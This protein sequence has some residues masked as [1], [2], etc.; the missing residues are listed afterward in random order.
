MSGR[1][2]SNSP[3]ARF[4]GEDAARG[5]PFALLGVSPGELSDAQILEARDRRMR[6]IDAHPLAE[7]PEADEVRLSLYAAA[8]QLLNPVIRGQ[9]AQSWGGAKKAQTDRASEPKRP[10]VHPGSPEQLLEHDA[11]LAL[12]MFGG[13]NPRSLRR[14]VSIAHARG[15]GS[16]EVARTLRRLGRQ[17]RPRAVRPVPSRPTRPS[18]QP[19]PAAAPA[20][21]SLL[22]P[23]PDQ[24]DPAQQLLKMAFI[25]GGVAIVTLVVLFGGVYALLA[26][27]NARAKQAE[28]QAAIDDAVS[29][30]DSSPGA[31]RPRQSRPAPNTRVLPSPAALGDP[32]L[33]V[34][35]IDAARRGLE[36][37]PYESTRRFTDAVA[38]LASSWAGFSPTELDRANQSVERFVETVVQPDV[39]RL[40]IDA[41]GAGAVDLD[42]RGAPL[43]ASRVWSIVWSGGMLAQIQNAHVLSATQRS[44]IT[45]LRRRIDPADVGARGF[46]IGA[47]AGAH[48]VAERMAAS[49]GARAAWRRWVEVVDALARERELL[50]T[51]MLTDAVDQLLDSDAAHAERAPVIRDLAL[52]MSWRRQGGARR[53]LV[54]L[55][56]RS[57]VDQPALSALMDTLVSESAAIGLDATM[58][59]SPNATARERQVLADRLA[60]VWELGQDGRRDEFTRELI[61]IF[62]E[63]QRERA[64]G[65]DPI[66]R[67]GSVVRLAYANASAALARAE[68]FEEAGR[69][70]DAAASFRPARPTGTGDDPFGAHDDGQLTLAIHAAGDSADQKL[71]AI[72]RLGQ[73]MASNLG[74][75]DAETLLELSIRGGPRSVRERATLVVQ[76]YAASPAMVNALLERA[77]D[78]PATQQMRDLVEIVTARPVPRDDDSGAWRLDARRALLETLIEA[79]AS[80]GRG[81]IVAS[82][83]DEFGVAY[84]MAMG[85][86]ISDDGS[87]APMSPA[88]AARALGASLRREIERSGGA[89][90]SALR[91][92]LIEQ[93]RLERNAHARTSLQAFLVEQRSICESLGVLV[94]LDQRGVSGEVARILESLEQELQSADHVLD[95]I[96][97]TEA[98]I[99]RLWLLREG[100]TP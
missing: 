30:A 84:T 42:D 16:A 21:V 54:L 55:L 44:Q 73:R 97:A 10:P 72:D 7:T 37:T 40:T 19:K 86:S 18:T 25:V 51:D 80:G 28:T 95:Q 14:I 27:D 22:D 100:V 56:Q 3:T 6:L 67:L 75:S 52:A 32:S 91:P 66:V 74:P 69:A 33:I 77:D 90:A 87:W 59:L 43:D 35:E 85:D 94:A 96:G 41:I 60:Q 15:L 53:W 2:G 12:A 92:G 93:R 88:D 57:D 68:R 29:L 71:E 45:R 8:A 20:P 65:G 23:T 81:A 1:P 61:A 11:I 47:V 31:Q 26:S 4:L 36:F 34:H 9:L 83:E 17:R 48:A 70:L 63:A 76:R 58:T 24:I 39:M 13:W 82:C 64:S 78:L 38:L 89:R 79:I 50:R 5:G 99:A 62:E 46:T 49:G 98:T